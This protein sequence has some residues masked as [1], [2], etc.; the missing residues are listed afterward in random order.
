MKNFKL[1]NNSVHS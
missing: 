1:A